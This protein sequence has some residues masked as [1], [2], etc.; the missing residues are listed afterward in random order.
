MRGELDR[1]IDEPDKVFGALGSVSVSKTT[2]QRENTPSFIATEVIRASGRLAI[3]DIGCGTG[4]TLRSWGQKVSL[5]APCS[6]D[7][8]TMTGISKRD[9]S[10]KSRFA[11]TLEAC[12]GSPARIRYLVGLAEAMPQIKTD[13][14][15]VVLSY[16]ALV[17]SNRAVPWLAEMVRITKPGGTIL[18]NASPRQIKASHP[19]P[20]FIDT[21]RVRGFSVIHKNI[22]LPSDTP[23][24]GLNQR[25]H[26]ID[27]MTLIRID[28]PSS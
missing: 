3:A 5:E 19:L 20:P 9:Y 28:I 24:T 6:P 4:N 18:C 15:D 10:D 27:A 23:R 22:A 13:S 25:R 17:H 7:C 12:S 16:N 1:L 26:T 8:I 14:Q 11:E 2:H 21:L